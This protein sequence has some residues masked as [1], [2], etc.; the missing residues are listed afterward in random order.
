[1]AI[2][3]RDAGLGDANA[4]ASLF[5]AAWRA[6]YVKQLSGIRDVWDEES[7]RQLWRRHFDDPQQTIVLAEEARSLLG[8]V[9]FGPDCELASTEAGLHSLY[10]HPDV[11]GRGVGTQLLDHAIAQCDA[12]GRSGMRLW[13][14]ADDPTAIRFYQAQGW[15]LDGRSRVEREF[16]APK[17]GMH[18]PLGPGHQMLAEMTAQPVILQRLIERRTAVHDAL[19]GSIRRDLAGVILVAR[20]SSDNAAVYGRYVLE[21]SLGRPVALAA[22]SLW[23][24]YGLTEDLR[25]HLAVAVSQSGRTPEIAST[26]AALKRAGAATVALTS[27]R[28]SPI[29]EHADLTLQL[30]AGQERAVPA[31]KTFTAEVAMFA[32]IAEAL[33]RPSWREADWAAVPDAQQEIVADSA[34]VLAAARVLAR[35]KANLHLAR[36]MLYPIALEAALKL[37]ETS[38]LPSIGFSSADFLHGPVASAPNTAVVAYVADGPVAEDVR[39]AAQAAKHAGA[40]VLVVGDRAEAD[41]PVPKAA[42]EPLAPLIHILRAQQLALHTA[43]LLGIDP[44]HPRRLKKVTAT[45]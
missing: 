41:I 10:V 19:R 45:V 40:T 35:T 13:V 7:A 43:L 3:L 38:T 17:L 28:G 39:Q 30:G 16:I 26:L 6:A 18:R 37:S 20:G 36:G 31:T 42:A 9:R 21:L 14:F 2:V 44:D 12:A 4:I 25:G 27:E 8:I 22:P 34:P 32:L 11:A 33:G 5:L 29:S 23:T 15:R 1:M 24:R